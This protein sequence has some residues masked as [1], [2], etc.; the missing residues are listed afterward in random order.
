M[1]LDNCK[2]RYEL[3]KSKGDDKQA[4]LWEE[5]LKDRGFELSKPEP[6]SKP[7]LKAKSLK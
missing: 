3:Y 2:K 6:K 1:T 7:E 4:A 5:R